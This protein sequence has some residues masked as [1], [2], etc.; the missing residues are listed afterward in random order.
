M[1]EKQGIATPKQRRYCTTFETAHPWLDWAAE[2]VHPDG[3]DPKDRTV[4]ELLSTQAISWPD[5][6]EPEH[7]DLMVV[8]T[9]G[10][11]E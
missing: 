11:V 8:W 10:S 7:P 6:G 2:P 3:D 5:P 9:W 4:W 1:S